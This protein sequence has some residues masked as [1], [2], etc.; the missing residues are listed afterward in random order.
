MIKSQVL[1]INYVIVPKHCKTHCIMQNPEKQSI[2]SLCS[3]ITKWKHPKCCFVNTN[4]NAKR[5]RTKNR[6]KYQ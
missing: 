6:G 4:Q 3:N 1:G 2:S 5:E